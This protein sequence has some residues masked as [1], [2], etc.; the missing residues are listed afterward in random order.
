MQKSGRSQKGCEWSKLYPVEF[1]RRHPASGGDQQMPIS[2]NLQSL[3][4]EE[5]M[6]HENRQCSVV[7]SLIETQQDTVNNSIS[8]IR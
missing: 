8:D 3:E 7:S 6:R 2:F 5:T 4:F 1:C